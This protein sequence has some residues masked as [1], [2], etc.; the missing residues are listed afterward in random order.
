MKCQTLLALSAGLL[1]SASSAHSLTFSEWQSSKFNTGELADPAISG[2][3]A[4]PDGDGRQNLIEYAYGLEPFASDQDEST[5]AV[6]PNGLTLTYPEVVAAT[7]IL[8]HLM[9]S[10]RDLNHW[11]TPNTTTRTVLADDGTMRLVSIFNP[12]APATFDRWFNRL[13]VILTPDGTESLAAPTRVDAKVEVPLRL[14]IGWNDNTKIETGFAVERR[15][16][17]DG[18]WE[19]IGVVAADNCYF[20]DL[21]IAPLT[22][23]IYR[24]SAIQGEYA[25]DYSSEFAITTPADTDGDGIPDDMES[26]YAVDPIMFS[27]GNNGIPDGWWISYGMDPYSDP[28][29]DPDGDGRS[30]YR[31][32][33][34]G[35]DPT[36]AD[37]AP[38]PG[39]TAPLAAS[40]LTLT[41]LDN[42][43]NE[44][45]WT[46]ND[47]AEGIIVERTGDGATWQTVGVI[48]G[49]ETT[50]T[51]E[52]SQPDL[53]YFY[54]V[55][56]FN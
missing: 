20:V 39:A 16:G 34:D 3:N 53:V 36:T 41:T 49:T 26:M 30:N 38:N 42:G 54:R 46:N 13:H 11:V 43:H 18:P 32:F 27:S 5:V 1:F 50:F 47:T 24:V 35:T 55:K 28:N 22:E 25:S 51:D 48:S 31:E 52:T 19:E 7:D 23:Y 15:M 17:T 44:L 56:A 45:A 10:S 6:G 4:D 2:A 9:E 33:L 37:S 29:A 21:D 14:R 40:D 12:N 8:Y